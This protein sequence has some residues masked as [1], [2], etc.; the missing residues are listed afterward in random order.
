VNPAATTLSLAAIPSST[1]F[2]ATVKLNATLKSNPVSST[3]PLGQITFFNGTTA[4]G[5][6]NLTSGRVAT[7]LISTLPTGTNAITARYAGNTNFQASTSNAVNVVIKP[8]KTTVALASSQ[9][10]AAL[11]SPV[12]FTASITSAISGTPTGTVTFKMGAT[13]LGTGKVSG[14]K[15]T[16][17][18]SSLKV[19]THTIAA[20]YSGDT[21]FATSQGTVQQVIQ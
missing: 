6:V 7:L 17:T 21:D 14:G 1:T 16:F 12:T 19:G 18:T 5:T 3:P 4:I 13:V 8:A 20:V 11:G 15:S 9:N 10:P 2:G